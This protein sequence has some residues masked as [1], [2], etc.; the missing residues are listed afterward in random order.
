MSKSD[1]DFLLTQ[2]HHEMINEDDDVEL[3]STNFE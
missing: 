1:L 3:E 2:L